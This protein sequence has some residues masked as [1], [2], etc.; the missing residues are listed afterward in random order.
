MSEQRVFFL[1]LGGNRARVVVEEAAR[2]AAAGGRATVVVDDVAQWRGQRFAPG[3]RVVELARLQRAHLP[4]AAEQLVVHRAPRK[5]LRMLGRGRLAPWSQ[6]AARAYERR[7]ASR[8]HRRVFLP[9][10]E[11]LWG[12]ARYRLLHRE[13]ARRGP[14]DLLVVADPVSI[15]MATRLAADGRMF[16]NVAYGLDSVSPGSVAQP[17]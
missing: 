16:P 1:A 9:V 14:F 10:Y 12:D 13:A 15:P 2:L 8:V 6:R 4:V 3:V 7:V 17:A 5:A 11:R